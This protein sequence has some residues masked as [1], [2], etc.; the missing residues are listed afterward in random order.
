MMTMSSRK[1]KGLSPPPRLFYCIIAAVVLVLV[2]LHWDQTT[3]SDRSSNIELVPSTVYETTSPQ[4]VVTSPQTDRSSNIELVPVKTSP[5]IVVTSP[6]TVENNQ[7]WKTI[8]VFVGNTQDTKTGKWF[9]QVKQDSLII[10]LLRN[11]RQGFFIDLA[12][13]EARKLSNTYALERS[14]GWEGLCIEPNPEYWFDLSRFR[15]CKIVAA[16]VGRDRMEEIKFNYRGVYGGITRDGFS[17]SVP[18][19]SPSAEPSFGRVLHPVLL[20][21]LLLVLGPATP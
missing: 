7:G 16:V 12:A 17:S 14:F 18:S 11:K 3:V 9:S 5:Q 20:P 13:N 1:T 6:Q 15:T 2:F 8:E 21:A 10:G 4:I 19:S